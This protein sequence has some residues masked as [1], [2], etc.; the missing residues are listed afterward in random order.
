MKDEPGP[1]SRG[2]PGG[3]VAE[4]FIEHAQHTPTAAPP[5]A[6]QHYLA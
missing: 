3:L 6:P 4:H 2:L 1:A 5:P